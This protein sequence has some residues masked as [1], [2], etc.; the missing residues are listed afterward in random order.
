MWMKLR[1]VVMGVAQF[2]QALRKQQP[3]PTQ[4]P[5]SDGSDLDAVS[6]GSLD[7]SADTN[8]AEQ[9]PYA[10]DSIK[11]DPTDDR[12]S[13][14]TPQNGCRLRHLTTPF[15]SLTR[16]FFLLSHCFHTA[17]LHLLPAISLLLSLPAPSFLTSFLS[18]SLL[19]WLV[20]SMFFLLHYG[21][22]AVSLPNYPLRPSLPACACAVCA[23]A[24]SQPR[25]LGR[26][27]V[28]HPVGSLTLGGF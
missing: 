23:R 22:S 21:C 14:G 19:S 26:C 2:R 8:T 12:R 3:P 5:L 7:S 27:G 15:L 25:G 18:S 24:C 10:P 13:T 9:G 1:N 17:S 6:H 20:V 11:V 16:P 28:G 4:S